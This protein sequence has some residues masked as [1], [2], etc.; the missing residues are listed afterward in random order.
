[1]ERERQ[2]EERKRRDQERAAQFEA[3]LTGKNVDEV[4]AEKEAKATTTPSK[5]RDGSSKTMK[6]RRW[7]RRTP[8]ARREANLHRG[9]WLPSPSIPKSPS[10]PS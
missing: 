1:M 8:P 5:K 9:P 7:I 3:S 4:K 2:A 10:S 6:R